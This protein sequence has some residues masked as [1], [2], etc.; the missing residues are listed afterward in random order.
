M[1]AVYLDDL[2]PLH[3]ER[4]RRADDNWRDELAH[5]GIAL[6][7]RLDVATKLSLALML[8]ARSTNMQGRSME[9]LTALHAELVTVKAI[10]DA[11]VARL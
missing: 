4:E 10:A 7:D 1:H 2:A 5:M 11:L 8:H 6:V 9:G 3:D